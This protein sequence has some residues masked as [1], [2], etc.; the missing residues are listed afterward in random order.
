[1]VVAGIVVLLLALGLSYWLSRR[2]LRPVRDLAQ[3]AAAARRGDYDQR[4]RVA[5]GDEVGELARTFNTLLADLREKRDME[6]YMN[7]L[8]RSLSVPSLESRPGAAADGPSRRDGASGAERDAETTIGIDGTRADTAPSEPQRPALG[9]SDPRPT[10]PASK[11]STPASKG[12]RPA[13]KPSAPTPAGLP[14]LRPGIVL[15]NRWEV[16]SSLGEG[17]MGLVVQARDRDLE[18]IVALKVLRPEIANDRDMLERLKSELKLARRITHPNVV[19]TFD[20]LELDGIP[21]ISM[22]Y[23]HGVTLFALLERSGRLP[24]SAGLHLARQLGAGLAAAHFQG[25]IHRDIKPANLILQPNGNAKLMD[26]GIARPVQQVGP[27]RTEVGSVVGT[28]HYL[29][30]EQLTGGVVDTRADIYATGVLLYE[31]F[32]GQRPY[33]GRTAYEI[34]AQHLREA[35]TPPRTYW[36]EMPTEL[37]RV[38]LRCLER[39]PENRFANIRDLLAAMEHLRGEPSVTPHA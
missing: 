23:V 32:T 24:Y 1:L 15:A 16:L 26:F 25:V 35:P 9:E 18:E 8:S 13:S 17:G 37:E 20:F 4:V 30:P 27:S 22:E 33:T 12:R 38:L 19:R 28:P 31:V 6:H 3:A 39:S 14:Q 7:D 29:A 2:T 5:G 21:C 10:P 36:P 11:E 34:F